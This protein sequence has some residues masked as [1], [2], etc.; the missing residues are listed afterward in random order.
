M[1]MITVMMVDSQVTTKDDDTCTDG[2]IDVINLGLDSIKTGINMDM[3]NQ[4]REIQQMVDA[5]LTNNGKYNCPERNAS[6]CERG[7]IQ[8]GNSCYMRPLGTAKWLAA[9][10]Y[11]KDALKSHL[12][13]IEDKEELNK[14]QQTFTGKN[15]WIGANRHLDGN[16]YWEKCEAYN[17][18]GWNCQYALVGN[19]LWASSYPSTHSN[20]NYV[21]LYSSLDGFVNYFDN[22]YNFICEYE[23]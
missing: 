4:L 2:L 6:E 8:I 11:C 13:T 15:Q 18:N 21:Y 20:Y 16:F 19:D 14:L 7:W 1:L 3:K 12:V 22:S 9:R 10:D 23:M 5:A 17:D